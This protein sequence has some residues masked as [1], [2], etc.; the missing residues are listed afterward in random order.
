[1]R[2]NNVKYKLELLRKFFYISNESGEWRVH[3]GLDRGAL[4][5]KGRCVWKGDIADRLVTNKGYRSCNFPIDG[6]QTHV[7]AHIV[8]WVL[9]NEKDISDDFDIDHENLN[10]IDNNP[11]DNLRLISHRLNSINCSRS[12]KRRMLG[13]LEDKRRPKSQKRFSVRLKN[14]STGER[15]SS[16]GMYGTANEAKIAADKLILKI[17]GP[18][19]PTNR[20]MGFL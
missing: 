1:M 13:V 14:F 2:R 10:K 18:D 8:I 3:H 15:L 7:L 19:A 9:Y 6:K 17:Y 5:G 16:G 12:M 4:K 20:S 11:V